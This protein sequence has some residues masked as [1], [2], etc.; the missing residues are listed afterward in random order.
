MRL[1]DLNQGVLML[2][3]TDM[4]QPVDRILAL[5][6][7][8]WSSPTLRGAS[9]HTII[10]LLTVFAVM[11]QGSVALERGDWVRVSSRPNSIP[12]RILAVSGDRVRIENSVL[13]L[14]GVAVQGIS[15]ELLRI[16]SPWEPEIIPP[17]QYFVV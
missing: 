8:D 11:V 5:G 3:L 17:G 6:M 14:N 2:V 16:D 7:A 12:V 9:M 10:G 1:V 13:Y 15:P 4:S